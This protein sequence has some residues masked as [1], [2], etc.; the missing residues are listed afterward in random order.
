[1]KNV[2]ECQ[3]DVDELIKSVASLTNSFGASTCTKCPV[4][5]NFKSACGN[6][7]RIRSNSPDALG[8]QKSINQRIIRKNRS[9][10]IDIK[11][12]NSNNSM[13][14]LTLN[15]PISIHRQ[16]ELDFYIAA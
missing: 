13:N 4:S 14:I 2:F 1:M 6:I 15:S 11:K 3:V 7:P 12:M 8:K 16:I 10:F 9:I 5:K